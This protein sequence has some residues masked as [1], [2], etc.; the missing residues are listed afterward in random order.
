LQTGRRYPAALG[1]HG[2]LRERRH[3]NVA[4][5]ALANKNAR[6]AWALLS[7]GEAYEPGLTV[8]SI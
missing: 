8:G 4:A 7:S 3:P 2:K 1:R 5:V 6:I